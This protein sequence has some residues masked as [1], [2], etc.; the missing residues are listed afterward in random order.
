MSPSGTRGRYRPQ[1]QSPS[2]SPAL[3]KRGHSAV[4]RTPGWSA[5]D[6]VPIPVAKYSIQGTTRAATNTNIQGKAIPQGAAAAEFGAALAASRWRK[7]SIINRVV[8]IADKVASSSTH[9]SPK[10]GFTTSFAKAPPVRGNPPIPKARI[11]ASA[12][13]HQ[14]RREPVAATTPT[15]R[16]SAP[17]SGRRDVEG[18][19]GPAD[20]PGVRR[21]TCRR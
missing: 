14:R 13:T 4:R 8:P 1:R 18:S 2:A 7:C 3:I 10:T 9:P 16:K 12:S 15:A 21:N 20:S 6:R 11:A 17:S 19:T 5:S